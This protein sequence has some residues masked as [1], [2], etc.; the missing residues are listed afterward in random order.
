[1]IL[2]SIVG[3]LWLTIVGVGSLALVTLGMLLAQLFQ[4]YFYNRETHDLSGT[5]EAVARVMASAADR[6]EALLVA[7][8]LVE[9][10]NRKLFVVSPRNI[11]ALP[12]PMRDIIHDPRVDPAWQGERVVY[13]GQYPVRRD[14]GS[15]YDT[16]IVV[17]RGF[18]SPL[19]KELVVIYEST[20]PVKESIAR[21]DQLI[22]WAIV[23]SLLATTIYALF[24]TRRI[25]HPLRQMIRAANHIAEGNYNLRLDIDFQDEIGSLA[26][27]FNHMTRQL[28][29]TLMTLKRQTDERERIFRS[30][31]EGVLSVDDT[32][33]I[34][35]ANPHARALLERV[36]GVK[37]RLPEVL[38]RH[39]R[40]TITERKEREVLI[41]E[42]GYA[43]VVV[44][45][46]LIE[47]E[48]TLGAV[49]V[50]RDITRQRQLDRLRQDFIANVSHELKTPLAMLQGYS[51]ALLDGMYRSPEE[52]REL[53]NILYEESLRMGRLVNDLLDYTRI[54]T[55]HFTLDI[56]EIPLAP[57]FDH[58]RRRYSAMFA[59][60]DVAFIIDD[61]APGRFWLDRDRLEQI[62]INLIDNALRYTPAGGE[63]R[64]TAERVG[65]GLR[66]VVRDTGEGIAK[67][68]LPFVFER[69]YKTDKSRRRGAGGTG[70]GLA[71][72]KRLVEA[73]GGTISVEST[74]GQGTA[75]TIDLPNASIPPKTP[76]PS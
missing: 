43:V 30:L 66:L 76:K 9:N 3:K 72:V 20:A 55:G 54:E 2:R 38:M 70:L 74:L 68:D 10:E 33:A 50:L 26:R 15:F 47:E 67:D 12:V 17:A 34:R 29:E 44:T 18:E 24:L 45:S 41:E 7:T 37:D 5:A 32:L 52:Q 57:L 14:G 40:A 42:Q 46:P 35:F 75:F 39:F 11:A 13:Q 16:L 21:I 64:L 31:G 58:L 62:L 71:I 49:G 6:D 1:M 28:E 22:F 51:E 60:R 8:Q 65:A 61:R 27:S 53:I 25:T 4:S 63:I 69:F 73:H 23:F 56:E 19:G 36:F 48:R 59:E